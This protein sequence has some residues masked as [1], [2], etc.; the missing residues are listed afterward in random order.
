MLEA[1]DAGLP[2]A[3]RVA[4]GSR[5]ADLADG[6]GARAAR[7]SRASSRPSTS[8]SPQGVEA[9]AICFLF[10]FL[11]PAHERRAR[12]II[13]ERHPEL[14]VSLS[15]EVDPAFREYERTVVTAFDA[16]VKPVVDRYLATPGSRPRRR[17]ACS[18]PL[19][20]MQ[21]RGGARGSARRAPRPVRLFLSGPAAGVIGGTHGRRRSAGHDD[22]ITIDIGGTSCD[23]ALIEQRRSRIIRSEGKIDGYHGP[24]ADGGRE[25]DR[26]GRRQHRLARRRRRRCASVR[27]RPAPS[28]AP[29]ATA[30]AA[31]EATVTD[32]SVVLGYLDPDYFAGGTHASSIPSS[33]AQAIERDGREAARHLASKQAALGIH[34]VV[35]AQMAEGIRLVSISRGIDPR[36]F[37]LVPLGGGGAAARDRARA[38]ARHASVSSCRA[39]PGVLSAAGLLVGARSSTR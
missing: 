19:Q 38:R 1:R 39:H 33:R 16:Y 21:S 29:P 3:G 37:T 14:I 24:R 11:N 36:D 7:R 18:A 31:Q 30:A 15:S 17:P 23:I 20:I 22:L 5:R 12:E 26:R 9:I 35:N 4:A 13:R 28:R 25:R 10:S 8:S 2:G 34:R 27:N 32:A 6:R